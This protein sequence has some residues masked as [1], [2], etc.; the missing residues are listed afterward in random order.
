MLALEGAA[1]GVLQEACA[2]LENR[3]LAEGSHNG[4][5]VMGEA[6]SKEAVDQAFLTKHSKAGSRRAMMPNRIML[7]SFV[8]SMEWDRPSMDIPTPGLK[9]AHLIIDRRASF[10]KRDPSIA[11]MSDLYPTLL[12]VPVVARAVEYIIPFL[13]FMD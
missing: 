3:A 5:Q 9:A 4:D 8:Q 1:Q 7:S 6:P 2:T 13:G 10:N 11:H 12:R